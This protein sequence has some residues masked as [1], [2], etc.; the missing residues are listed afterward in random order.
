MKETLEPIINQ[1]R[2][3]ANSGKPI[4]EKRKIVQ[5][6]QVAKGAIQYINHILKAYRRK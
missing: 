2:K 1:M 6:V 5:E 3:L 4:R